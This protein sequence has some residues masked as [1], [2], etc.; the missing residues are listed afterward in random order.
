MAR[1]AAL[2]HEH[3]PDACVLGIGENGHLAFNDPPADFQTDQAL[4]VVTLD[5]AC[6]RQQVGEGHF[7]AM[8]EVPRQALTLTVPAL[9]APAHVLVVVPEKRKAVAVQRALE[10]PV[11]PDCPASILRTNSH[12][13]LY[14]DRDS[15]SL[16]HHGGH[17]GFQE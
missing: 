3:K 17:L 12:V 15:A 14:L 5:D 1:Y 2:L 16:L 13:H 8:D 6:R 11:S 4:A 10:G 7:G 9:L